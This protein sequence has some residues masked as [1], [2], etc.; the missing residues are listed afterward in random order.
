V[1]ADTKHH[2]SAKNKRVR[3][4]CDCPKP[5]SLIAKKS[6]TGPRSQLLPQSWRTT[7]KRSRDCR[8]ES[9]RATDGTRAL[10]GNPGILGVRGNK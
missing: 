4:L 3:E 8:L 10:A 5:R 2:G 6:W 9:E 7:E 1:A